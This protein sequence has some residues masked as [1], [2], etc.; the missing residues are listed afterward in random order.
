MP[1]DCDGHWRPLAP[2]ERL[3]HFFGYFQPLHRFRRLHVS[4]KLHDLL[5]CTYVGRQS[6]IVGGDVTITGSL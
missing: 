2:T 6:L 4:S 3:N 5:P 1:V